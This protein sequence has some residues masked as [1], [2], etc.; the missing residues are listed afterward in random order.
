LLA[1]PNQFFCPILFLILYLILIFILISYLYFL[2]D[3]SLI[4]FDIVQI[5]FVVFLKILNIRNEWLANFT[6]NVQIFCSC[7]YIVLNLF[8]IIV[9]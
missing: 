9:E 8:Y 1:D 3:D 6:L 4:L 2:V 5:L 7:E